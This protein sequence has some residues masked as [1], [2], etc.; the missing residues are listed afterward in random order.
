MTDGKPELE[1]LSVSA[2]FQMEPLHKFD[3]PDKVFTGDL[4]AL[5]W[6]LLDYFR[7]NLERFADPRG[8][9]VYIA[10]TVKRGEE[11]ESREYRSGHYVKD[12]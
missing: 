5:T 11:T 1:G 7:H 8:G 6:Q 10:L 12:T 4:Q 9:D 2:M 3:Q